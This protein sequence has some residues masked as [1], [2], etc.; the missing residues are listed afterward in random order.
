[1]E[2]NVDEG[3]GLIKNREGVALTLETPAHSVLGQAVF[4]QATFLPEELFDL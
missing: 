3:S 1:V 4:R 2:A